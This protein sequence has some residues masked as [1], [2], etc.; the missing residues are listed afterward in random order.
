M[1]SHP[2]NAEFRNYPKT[3]THVYCLLDIR[4]TRSV[5]ENY[6]SYFSTKTY[7]VGSQKNHLNEMVPLSTQTY[8]VHI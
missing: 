7:A 8:N 6:F 4:G 2:Q 5:D 1:E 3:F